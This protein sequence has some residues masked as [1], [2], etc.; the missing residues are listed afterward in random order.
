MIR[1]I[2]PRGSQ[3]ETGQPGSQQSDKGGSAKP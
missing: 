2:P 3:Q 1:E